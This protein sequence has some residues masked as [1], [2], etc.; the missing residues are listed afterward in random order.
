[1]ADREI[2]GTVLAYFNRAQGVGQQTA[3]AANRSKQARENQAKE[4]GLNKDKKKRA[5]NSSNL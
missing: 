1:M 2:H 3:G 4:L 5:E